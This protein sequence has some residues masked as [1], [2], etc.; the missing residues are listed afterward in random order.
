LGHKSYAQQAGKQ[1]D[2]SNNAIETRSSPGNYALDSWDLLLAREK[3]SAE[4]P[5]ILYVLPA[6]RKNVLGL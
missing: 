4:A 6:K 2:A 5:L 3:S 1:K